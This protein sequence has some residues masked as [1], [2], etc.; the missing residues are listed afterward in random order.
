MSLRGIGIPL[1][2]LVSA[3][4]TAAPYR[5]SS[6]PPADAPEAK[7]IVFAVDGA[8]NFQGSSTALRDYVQSDGLPLHVHTFEWSHGYRRIF[9]DHLDQ[10]HARLSGERLAQE[11]ACYKQQQPES[12]LPI[13]IV[14][15][16]AGC[17]V[18][19]RAAEYLPLDSIE[20]M[21]LLAPSVSADFEIRP[22][23]RCS[24]KG[25]EV[26]HSRRDRAYL[27]LG[28]LLFG[29]GDHKR[30]AVAGRVGFSVPCDPGPDAAL[31]T[32]LHQH[33]WDPSISWTGYTGGHF[34]IY[35][36]GY[37]RAA[38]AP[39]LLPAPNAPQ[40]AGVEQQLPVTRGLSPV[41]GH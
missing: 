19:L 41:A 25:V 2:L 4:C 1:L 10:E 26:F 33:P 20:C 18:A 27:G 8:G 9:A 29:T 15:H 23:L 34:N 30:T 35:E 22:A 3:G 24:R 32:R 7:A 36:A 40:L 38:V 37:L 28:M 31:Y 17:Q 21:V 14:A 13:H 5:V 12:A 39:L 11:I 6:A 16:S